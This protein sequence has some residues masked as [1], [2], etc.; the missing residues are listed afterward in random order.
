MF[1]FGFRKARLRPGIGGG[2][3]AAWTVR[4]DMGRVEQKAKSREWGSAQF[5]VLSGVFDRIGGVN[6]KIGA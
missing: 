6:D 2:R 4:V 5:S 1:F 3:L